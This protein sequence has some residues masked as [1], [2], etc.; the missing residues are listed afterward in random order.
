M[1]N[2]WCKEK[3]SAATLGSFIGL[4]PEDEVLVQGVNCL[5]RCNKVSTLQTIDTSTAL[6]Y[7][8]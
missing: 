1:H 6:W 8:R 2:R 7:E 4:A 3:G 5:G